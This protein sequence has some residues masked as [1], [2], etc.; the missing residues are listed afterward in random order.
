MFITVI[1]WGLSICFIK[2]NTIASIIEASLF[3]VL[4]LVMLIFWFMKYKV[5]GFSF[6]EVHKQS[7]TKY[8]EENS[9]IAS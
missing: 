6:V 8:K 7:Q 5:L 9:D 4:Y 3:A 1:I 2:Q